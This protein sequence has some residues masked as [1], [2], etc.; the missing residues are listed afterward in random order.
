MKPKIETIIVKD[1]DW[2]NSKYR[3]REWEKSVNMKDWIHDYVK[4]E[5]IIRIIV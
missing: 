3:T 5:Y 4:Q 1:S 2:K